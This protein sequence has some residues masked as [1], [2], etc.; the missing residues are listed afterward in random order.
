MKISFTFI[1]VLADVSM[2]SKLLSSAYSCASYK[3]SHQRG[4]VILPQKP[5]PAPHTSLIAN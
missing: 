4:E 5:Q 3:Q 1:A 2:N